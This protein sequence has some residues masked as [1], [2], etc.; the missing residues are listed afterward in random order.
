[1]QALPSVSNTNP[2][3][4]TGLTRSDLALIRAAAA[5][6]HE[7]ERLV[8]FGSRAKGSHRRGSDVDLL[9]QGPNLSSDTVLALSDELNEVAPLPYFFDLVD[10]NTLESSTLRAHIERVG[11]VLYQ[12]EAPPPSA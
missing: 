6:H 2:E 10:D 4:H 1:M 9:V 8:L 11:I 7:V 5:R 3:Q 12:R